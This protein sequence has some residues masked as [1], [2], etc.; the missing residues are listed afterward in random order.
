MWHAQHGGV[1]PW[2][3]WCSGQ[4]IN[5]LRHPAAQRLHCS[6]ACGCTN[7]SSKQLRCLA[8]QHC[9]PLDTC[10]H[11]ALAPTGTQRHAALQQLHPS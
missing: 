7:S 4:Q 8:T 6:H 11:L 2:P 3:R 9:K 5:L 10:K 1:G